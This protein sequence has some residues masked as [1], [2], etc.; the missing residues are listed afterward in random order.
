MMYTDSV[1]VDELLYP[2]RIWVNRFIPDSEGAGRFRGSSARHVEWSP[3]DVALTAVWMSDGNAYPA[4][5]A[6]GG[7]A[8]ALA[9]Q[10]VRRRSGEVEGLPAAG[11]V[12]IEPDERL[13]SHST[14]GGG[15]GPPQERDPDRVALDVSDGYVTDEHAREVYRVALDRDGRV[16]PLRTAELRAVAHP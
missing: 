13:V 14:S 4:L 11:S 16:D 10:H 3:V 12:V 2:F 7:L 5:G 1:E 9:S 15:Y 6:R 8:G